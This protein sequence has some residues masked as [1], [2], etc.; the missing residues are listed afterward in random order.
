VCRSSPDDMPRSADPQVA[1]TRS[2]A[3]ESNICAIDPQGCS[4]M[5][6]TPAPCG[7]GYVLPSWNLGKRADRVSLAF[8]LAQGLRDHDAYACG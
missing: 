4:Q 6:T 3:R 2:R 7:R 5:W 1:G 8:V